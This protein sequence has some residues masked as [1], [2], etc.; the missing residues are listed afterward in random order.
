MPIEKSV[1]V[2]DGPEGPRS[3]LA[4]RVRALGYRALRAKTPEEAFQLVAEHRYQVAAALIP[5]EL[6]V[7][8][9][10]RAL[11]ALA[12][13]A[14]GGALRYIVA[15]PR[16]EAETLAEL[17]EAGVS[18]ALWEP[19][20]TGRLRFQLNR[21]LDGGSAHRRREEARAPF[22][23]PALVTHAGREKS[24]RLY[25]LSTRGAYLETKRPAQRGVGVSIEIPLG[26]GPL[27][28]EGRVMFTNVPGNLQRAALPVGMG[29]EFTE[30]ADSARAAI[31]RA[32]AEVALALAV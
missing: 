7:A 22:D 31:R 9:L 18:L 29:I 25:T 20:G 4:D 6:T 30:V 8:D 15:G 21:A 28:L 3:G 12:A 14:P 27:L 11:E 32:V 1:L 26:A 24:A 23:V 13:R 17:R 19:H 16:P 10:P 5:P 2:I